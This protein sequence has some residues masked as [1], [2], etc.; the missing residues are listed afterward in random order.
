MENPSV[1]N[2][3]DETNDHPSKGPLGAKVNVPGAKQSGTG[4]LASLC[5]IAHLWRAWCNSWPFTR[6]A[7]WSPAHN[8]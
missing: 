7:V 4:A 2:E 8:P 5:A 6:W 3:A 1:A